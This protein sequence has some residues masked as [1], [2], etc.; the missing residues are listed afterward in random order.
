MDGRNLLVTLN[1]RSLWAYVVEQSDGLRI[2]FSPDDWEKVFLEPGQRV[3]IRLP[4][5][6]E[7]RVF[8]DRVRKEPPFVWITAVKRL[9]A[10]R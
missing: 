6:S 8:V 1:G 4:D 5:G 7:P 3:P 9:L 10:T 2:R